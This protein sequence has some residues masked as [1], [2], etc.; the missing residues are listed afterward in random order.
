[1]D[2]TPPSPVVAQFLI[3]AASNKL[4]FKATAGL[5]IPVPN[6]DLETGACMHG[7]LNVF[8]AGFLAYS[9]R[10][11]EDALAEVLEEYGYQDFSF[12]DGSLRFGGEEF[13]SSEIDRLRREW[14][15]SFGSCSFLEPVEHLESHGLI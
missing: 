2:L 5:H 3:S 15:L 11:D 9:G 10:S 6:E 14:M 13:T 8:C 7:F 12:G 4:P 1:P